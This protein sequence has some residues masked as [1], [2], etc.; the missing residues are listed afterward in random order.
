V[1]FHEVIPNDRRLKDNFSIIREEDRALLLQAKLEVEKEQNDMKWQLIADR[2]AQ[3]GG[4][5]YGVSR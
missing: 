2:I 5:E 1:V 3:A 4:D